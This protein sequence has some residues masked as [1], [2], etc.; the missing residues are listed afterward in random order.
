MLSK[1]KAIIFDMDGVIFDSEQIYYDACF[2]AAKRNN[3]TFSHEFVKQF[4]GKTSETC[5]IILQSHLQNSQLVEQLWHDWGAARNEILT[6]RGVPLK[7]GIEDLFLA[8]A[9]SPPFFL[10]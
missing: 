5:Q 9:D 3:L 6:T 7:E 1:M 2:M 10:I 4:V 8:L